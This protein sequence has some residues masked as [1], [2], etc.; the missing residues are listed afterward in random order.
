MYDINNKRIVPQRSIQFIQLNPKCQIIILGKIQIARTDVRNE[1]IIFTLLFDNKSKPDT[2]SMDGPGL[3]TVTLRSLSYP[4]NCK[5]APN[6]ESIVEPIRPNIVQYK[7]NWIFI[8]DVL[9]I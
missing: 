9:V 4:E 5:V 7:S 3:W 2:R 1:E 6:N 8:I